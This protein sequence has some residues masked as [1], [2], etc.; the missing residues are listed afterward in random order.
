MLTPLTLIL[1]LLFAQAPRVDD[2]IALLRARRVN[3]Q[4]AMNMPNFVADETARRFSGHG[5]TAQLRPADVIETEIAFTGSRA[6]RSRIRRN[7]KVWAKPFDALPGFK[8]YG[9]FGTELRPL[10]D[11]ECPT[12]FEFQG[13]SETRGRQ[14]LDYLFTSPPDGCFAEFYFNTRHEN[15]E[16]SGHVYIDAAGGHV[17]QFDEDADHFPAGFEMARRTEQV[18]W[19]DVK[20]GNDSHLLPVGATFDVYYSSG[21]RWRI[22]VE[23]KNHR[24]FEASS[25]ITFQ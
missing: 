17:I 7:G 25:N 8:W 18:R 11:P 2:R 22:E 10:F 14:T 1:I 9:G 4:Y 16:R 5:K 15:P 6:V 12:E 20:I 21:E 19:D 24:H 3:L 23:Y 13:R